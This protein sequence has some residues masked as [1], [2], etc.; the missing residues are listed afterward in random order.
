MVYFNTHNKR[1]LCNDDP[2]S[3]NIQEHDK[4]NELWDRAAAYFVGSIEAGND[5]NGDQRSGGLLLFNLGKQL[6]SEFNT[7]SKGF[8]K[9][10]DEIISLFRTGQG[11]LNGNQCNILEDT[12]GQIESLINVPLLQGLIRS[13]DRSDGVQAKSRS[14]EDIAEGFMFATVLLPII[15][16]ADPEAASLISQN[17]VQPF[18]TSTRPM[19]SGKLEVFDMVARIIPKIGISCENIGIYDGYDFC[20]GAAS[21]SSSALLT[22]TLSSTLFVCT[23]FQ[24]IFSF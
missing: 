4:K 23:L 17:M 9:I 14:N 2:V 18:K 20:K 12:I 22:S 24:I 1:I 13:A 3:H 19:P 5:D 11:A 15:D 16:R 6:C 10:N 21:Q 7:C 8:A